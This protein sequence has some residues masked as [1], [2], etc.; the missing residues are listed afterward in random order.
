MQTH[1]RLNNKKSTTSE[2]LCFPIPFAYN[3]RS[4]FHT[5]RNHGM[6]FRSEYSK[7]SKWHWYY[8]IQNS[9]VWMCQQGVNVYIFRFSP[10]KK[11]KNCDRFFYISWIVMAEN[12]CNCCEKNSDNNSNNDCICH[13]SICFSIICVKT[14]ERYIQW[15]G[16]TMSD[17][18]WKWVTASD[19]EWHNEWQQMTMSDSEWQK[20]LKRSKTAHLLQKMDDYNSFY[21]ENRYTILRWWY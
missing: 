12:W 11:L 2:Y 17:S 16:M 4:F 7:T 10:R 18:K 19:I 1:L 3:R 8:D 6:I 21:N 13:F 5:S 20:V 14:D 15:Q 9:K